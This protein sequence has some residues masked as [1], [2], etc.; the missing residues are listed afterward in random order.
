[1]TAIYSIH[2][3]TELDMRQLREVFLI[4]DTDNEL[5]ILDLHPKQLE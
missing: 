5:I 2:N 1:M 4:Q 3:M